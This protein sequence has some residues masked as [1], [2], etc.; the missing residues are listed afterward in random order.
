MGR[1]PGEARRYPG[2]V[3]KGSTSERRSALVIVFDC[4]QDHAFE[5]VIQQSKGVNLL[6][7]AEASA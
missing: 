6:S 1:D 2:T 4:E 7:V 5:L 3:A